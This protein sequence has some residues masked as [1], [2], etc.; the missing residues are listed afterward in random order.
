MQERRVGEITSDG[1]AGDTS[2]ADGDADVRKDL[3]LAGGIR[4]VS[5]VE[6]AHGQRTRER[7][8]EKPQDNREYVRFRE[9]K[10]NEEDGADHHAYEQ[11]RPP[12]EAFAKRA[13]EGRARELP[14]EV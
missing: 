5:E 9:A 7:A 1:R 14:E 13:V 4:D 12:A 3:A 2:T 11:H 8:L 10:G 6:L